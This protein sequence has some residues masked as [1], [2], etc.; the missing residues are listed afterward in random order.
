LAT[1]LADARVDVPDGVSALTGKTG[2]ALTQLR[3]SGKAKIDGEVYD[4]ITQGD[5]IPKDA[6]IKV[7]KV[8][9][10]RIIVLQVNA[11]E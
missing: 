4:V 11:D 1:T 5:F 8:K 3:P 10:N 2:T 9:N 7:V 6:A